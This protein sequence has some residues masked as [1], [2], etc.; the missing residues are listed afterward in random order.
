MKTK[1]TLRPLKYGNGYLRLGLFTDDYN[2]YVKNTKVQN[3]FIDFGQGFQDVINIPTYANK[4]SLTNK[5]IISDRLYQN[6]FTNS[7]CL[8][9]FELDIDMTTNTHSYKL[10]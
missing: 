3:L 5:S 8:L 1:I 9:T 6:G 10:L 2:K 4:G 7:K